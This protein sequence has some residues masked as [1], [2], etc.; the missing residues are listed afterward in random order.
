MKKEY[1]AFEFKADTVAT[2]G[3]I[4]GYAS[5]FG[6]LDLGFDI[7]DKGAF[8]KT[9]RESRGKFPIL[10]DHSPYKQIGLN[11]EAEEDSKGLY[12]KGQLNLEVM[13]AKERLAL[14]KQSLDNGHAPGLSIGYYTIKAEPDPA[15]T[16]V[17]RLKELKLVEYSFVT[18][19]MNTAAMVTGAKDVHAIDSATDLVKQLRLKGLSA[20][21]IEDALHSAIVTEFGAA[22]ENDPHTMQSIDTLMKALKNNK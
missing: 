12:V 8:K 20:K 7:V 15:N 13:L 14:A 17:R 11:L 3:L 5:T 4:E 22:V 19:P 9:L 1:M 6:N 16:S 2:E 21:E 10:A 18:F